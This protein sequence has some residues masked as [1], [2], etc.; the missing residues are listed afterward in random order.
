MASED[1]RMQ[2]CNAC[3]VHTI[4]CMGLDAGW[5]ERVQAVPRRHQ[6][7]ASTSTRLRCTTPHAAAWLRRMPAPR[8]RGACAHDAA[9]VAHGTHGTSAPACPPPVH[10]CTT[11]RP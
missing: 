2:Q 7:L 5:R 4:D 1:G 8:P 3:M 11:V 6:D 9:A 10:S